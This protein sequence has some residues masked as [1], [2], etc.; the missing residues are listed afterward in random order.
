MRD[1]AKSHDIHDGRIFAGFTLA[2]FLSGGSSS[3]T[4]LSSSDSFRACR[5]CCKW[6]IYTR[7]LTLAF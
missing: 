2:R 6:V 5:S 3:V 4:M 1:E 7:K